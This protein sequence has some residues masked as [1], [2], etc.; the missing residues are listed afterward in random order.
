MSQDGQTYRVRDVGVTLGGSVVWL[1]QDQ[2][3]Q[4]EAVL[5][6]NHGDINKLTETIRQRTA[7]IVSR[8]KGPKA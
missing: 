8:R 6:R 1:A 5:D 7:E 4:F 3:T 2:Q